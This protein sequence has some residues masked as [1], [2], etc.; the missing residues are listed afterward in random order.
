[1]SPEFGKEKD[2]KEIDVIPVTTAGDDSSLQQQTQSSLKE[3]IEKDVHLKVFV[4]GVGNAG[5]QTVSYGHKE[6]LNVFAINSSAKDMSDQIMDGTIP[7]FVVG[8]EAR[9]SGK[10]IEKGVALWKEN[11]RDLFTKNEKFMTSCQA[12]DI[13]VVTSA[14]GGGTGPSVSPEICRVLTTMFSK[15]I[16]LYHGI[17]PKNTDSNIA[18]SNT[19]YCLDEIRKLGIP[20]SLTDLNQFAD[21]P[22]DKAFIHADKHAVES[23]KAFAGMYLKISSS[24]MMDEN[25]M[26]SVIGEP[27]YIAAYI[28][29]GITS[30]KL[31]KKSMQSMIIDEM[32]KGPAVAIQKDGIA[33]Q[34][35]VII[36][37]PDDMTEVSRTGNYQEIYDFIGHKPKNGIY[38]N[39]GVTDG[40]DGQIILILSGMTYPINRVGYYVE[41]V[42]AQAEFLKRQKT[43]NTSADASVMRELV[44]NSTGKLDSNTEAS[45]DAINSALDALF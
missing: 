11:G 39:Y 42:K 27:G 21:E 1:M 18:F 17:V 43:I 4:I 30:T 35:A 28:V 44:S 8:N 25:D 45:Q 2:E 22:N 31:E 3:K 36:N 10:N 5:N 37:C 38:E 14:T 41:E 12:A 24:Q 15:K 40:T 32:R 16:I 23:I 19:V 9:G 6:G 33:M 20:Y 34:M 13:I 29:N 26:K 7:C